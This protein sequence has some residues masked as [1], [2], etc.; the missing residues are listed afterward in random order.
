MLSSR[1]SAGEKL[2]AGRASTALAMRATGRGPLRCSTFGCSLRAFVA[3]LQHCTRP[4]PPVRADWVD[5]DMALLHV[6]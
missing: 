3:A 4:S 5:S 2:E 6:W 1:S